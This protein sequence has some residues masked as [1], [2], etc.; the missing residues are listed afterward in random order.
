MKYATYSTLDFVMDEYFQQWVL[1]PTE[2]NEE[3]W[4]NWIKTHPEKKAAIEEAK[5]L[6]W[7]YGVEEKDLSAIH[8][9]RILDG[10][11]QGI[12]DQPAKLHMTIAPSR[13]KSRHFLDTW[14]KVAAI[15]IG[16]IIMAG[17]VYWMSFHS[18]TSY[19][20]AYGEVKEIVLPDGSQVTLNGNS[21]LHYPTR[22]QDE[23]VREVWLEGEAFFHVRNIS[24]STKLENE[25]IPEQ[26]KFVVHTHD[27]YVIVLGNQFNVNSRGDHVKVVLNSGKVK[28]NVAHATS[29]NEIF[30]EP[31]EMVAYDANRKTIGKQIVDPKIYS[32]WRE[33]Y[34]VFDEMPL[35]EVAEILENTY[36]LQIT[37]ENEE[38]SQE[39]I[40]GTVPS[41]DISVLLES[42]SHIFDLTITRQN[43]EIFIS[44]K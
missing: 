1:L 34:L 33:N 5:N 25:D 22:W 28:I 32:S 26:Y 44:K 35:H 43:N 40:R 30:M 27:L 15:F 38:L 24:Q 20:T 4:Q 3:F 21:N 37:F 19:A 10:I 13:S 9:E 17:A 8:I 42:L 14:Y 36:G 39:I 2:E 11:R 6:I 7:V 29:E 12:K 16:F 41:D 23:E 18:Q 31:G